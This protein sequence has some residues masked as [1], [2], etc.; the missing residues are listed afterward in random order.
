MARKYFLP[1][2][3]SLVL[4]VFGPCLLSAQNPESPADLPELA[5]ATR[6]KVETGTFEDIRQLDP[7]SETYSTLELGPVP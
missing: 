2:L 1:G 4:A 6:P 5:P 3:L 7:E